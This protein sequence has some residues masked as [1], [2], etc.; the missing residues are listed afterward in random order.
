MLA[1]CVSVDKSCIGVWSWAQYG[2]IDGFGKRL[3]PFK[4]ESYAP[5]QISELQSWV[6]KK[7]RN[8]DSRKMGYYDE[9]LVIDFQWLE[10]QR[11]K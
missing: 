4:R 6:L 7:K 2:R 10:K 5:W 8:V 3:F 11:A 9:V 1:S